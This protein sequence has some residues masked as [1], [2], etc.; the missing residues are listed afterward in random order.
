MP[1]H[2]RFTYE[3]PPR[4]RT[5]PVLDRLGDDFSDM[6]NSMHDKLP[7]R[8]EVYDSIRS[9]EADLMDTVAHLQLEVEALKFVQSGPSTLAIKTL[10]VQSKPVALCL[11]LLSGRMGGTTLRSPYNSCLTWRGCIECHPV[12]A[13]DKKGHVGQTSRGTNRTLLITGPVDRLSTPVRE[14]DSAGRG[15]P[16]HIRNNSGKT[17]G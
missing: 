15:G 12:G 1:E 7:P 9:P 6:P 2:S 16:V 3:L 8:A 17:C 14:D 13:G 10:P 5:P 4:I 11:T